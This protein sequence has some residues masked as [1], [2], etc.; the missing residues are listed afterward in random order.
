M[1]SQTSAPWW[2]RCYDRNHTTFAMQCNAWLKVQHVPSS[3]HLWCWD[4]IHWGCLVRP[5]QITPR[6]FSALSDKHHVWLL[7]AQSHE[8]HQGVNG[9]S[10]SSLQRTVLVKAQF[11]LPWLGSCFT[12]LARRYRIRPL[13][14][15]MLQSLS[16]VANLSLFTAFYTFLMLTLL[17]QNAFFAIPVFVVFLQK[18]LEAVTDSYKLYSVLEGSKTSVSSWSRHWDDPFRASFFWFWD[19]DLKSDPEY[20]MGWVYFGL[21]LLYCWKRTTPLLVDAFY[22]SGVPL[23]CFCGVW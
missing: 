23:F 13:A 11:G 5:N 15:R 16:H 10:K 14:P 21:L 3:S 9:A 20:L 8:K 1:A 17:E 18:S 19:I 6:M 2:P 12:S 22:L 7:T 4:K